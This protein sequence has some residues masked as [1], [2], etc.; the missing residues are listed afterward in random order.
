MAARSP[1]NRV[2][3][4]WGAGGDPL[5]HELLLWASSGLA[6][7]ETETDSSVGKADNENKV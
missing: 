6:A 5:S 2:R 7:G 1:G 3:E 4:K